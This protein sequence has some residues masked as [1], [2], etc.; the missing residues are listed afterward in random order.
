[1]ITTHYIEEARQAN[2]VG[3]MRFGRLLA[4]GHPDTLLEEYE[5][6]TL[7]DVFLHLCL[8]DETDKIRESKKL[9][10]KKKGKR[11]SSSLANGSLKKAEEG[12]ATADGGEGV[13]LEELSTKVVDPND[14]KTKDDER[15]P[16]Q[17]Q[18]QQQ[19][20]PSKRKTSSSSSS[21]LCSF[22]T[23]H[24]LTA[25]LAK[26]FIRMWR[27]IGFLLFQF[28]L[29]TVQ[30]A[31]FCLA[32][33]RDLRGLTMAVVNDDVP[34]L[35]CSPSDHTSGCILG[36][37]GQDDF[38]VEGGAFDFDEAHKR[39]L[40]CRFLSHVDPKVIKPA[41]YSDLDEALRAVKNGRHW[42]VLHFMSNFTDSLYSRL[43]AMVEM[44]VPNEDTLD[45]SEVH[46]YLDMTNQQVGY[47]I[48]LRLSE[49]YQEFSKVR[50]NFQ[51][52]YCDVQP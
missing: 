44:E 30:V 29:P 6:S 11:R 28:I 1:M 36:N 38:F 23:G 49:A 40:S 50:R 42:G 43:F 39:N 26:N 19:Q 3:M 41:Y 46:V 20:L 12:A 21:R 52:G 14:N 9:E 47:T 24:R 27:N 25:L 7:E 18:Q 16:L 37:R 2:V 51:D 8:G 13:P 5:R 17:Q 35:G 32:I 15:E 34:A 31:L 33:G 48:Q 22:L 4:E 45:R 10:E